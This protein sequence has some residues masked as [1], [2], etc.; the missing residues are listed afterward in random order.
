V[1]PQA[2]TSEHDE[3]SELLPLYLSG[4]LGETLCQRVQAHLQQCPDC[5]EEW[6]VLQAMRQA[7]RHEAAAIPLPPAEPALRRV[8]ARIERERAVAAP[9]ITL[10]ESWRDWWARLWPA[11]PVRALVT[12]QAV[13]VVALVGVVTW[14]GQRPERAAPAVPAAQVAAAAQRGDGLRFQ[15][16]FAPAAQQAQ[17]EAMLQELQASV[18]SG[19]GAA[20]FYHL[21]IQRPADRDPARV[22]DETLRT[23][24]ARP[25]LVRFAEAQ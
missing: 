12:V 15:V 19:P 10:R 25:D 21:E 2:S 16:A 17:I 6:Q 1:N 4:R 3:L 22:R 7:T 24:R 20:G 9:T 23:L 13:A 18:V 11:G 14:Q 8:L 5:H